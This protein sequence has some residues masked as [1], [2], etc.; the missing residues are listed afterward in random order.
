MR[1][2]IIRSALLG[3]LLLGFAMP[4]VAMADHKDKGCSNLGTFF[5]V[6][7]P[8]DT[9]LMGFAGTVTGNSEK[10]GTNS[11]EFPTFDPSFAGVPELEGKEPFVSAAY[12]GTLR[13]DWKRIGKS[14]FAYTFMGFAYNAD[15]IPVYIA[16]VSGQTQHFNHC[17]FE[18]ITAVMKVYLP[19][20]SPFYGDPIATIPLGEFYAYR[21]KVD[22]PY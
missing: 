11:F 2:S 13:G 21:A 10:M 12:I 8:D 9:R 22:H 16:K 1:N 3:I 20:M 17:Q 18:H 19:W 14:R 7:G 6:F 15:G 4:G 5:G